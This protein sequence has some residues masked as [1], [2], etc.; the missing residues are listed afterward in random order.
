MRKCR[1]TTLSSIF[2]ITIA[3]KRRLLRSYWLCYQHMSACRPSIHVLIYGFLA[4]AGSLFAEDKPAAPATPHWAFVAPVNADH[5]VSIDAYLTAEHKKQGLVPQEPAEDLI[6]LRR[7]Y[8]DLIGLPP[9]LSDQADFS[10]AVKSDRKAAMVSVVDRLLASPQYGERWG[11]HFMDIW[12]YSDWHGLGAQ[13]R[14]SQKHIWHWRDWIVESMNADKGYDRMIQEMLAGDELE[15]EN[16]DVLRATGFLARNYFLFNRTSWLDDMVEHT[17]KAF[18]GITMNC[19][20][21]HAHKYDPFTHEEYYAFRAIFEPYHVRLDELPGQT[22]LEK[23]GLPRAYDLHLD[24]PTYLHVKGDEKN[25]DT[26]KAILPAVP[27]VL[28]S[29]P[30]D[31]HPLKLPA[32]A[33]NPALQPWVLANHLATAQEQ[34]KIARAAVDKARQKLEVQDKKSKPAQSA[35]VNPAPSAQSFNDDFA[36]ANPRLW[37]ILDDGWAYR[38]GVLRQSRTA[39][40]RIAALS[41]AE[42]PSDF[43]ATVKFRITGGTTYKS[44][45]FA[46]DTSDDYEVLVY[47]S[48][49]R[50]APKLQ[51]AYGKASSFTYPAEGTQQRPVKVGENYELTVRVQGS[52]I[53]VSVNGEHALAFDLPSRKAGLFQLV[54]YDA[55]AEF[56]NFKLDPLSADVQLAKTSAPAASK[57]AAAV[58]VSPKDAGAALK[59][60]ELELAAAELRPAM[61]QAVYNADT[62]K[63]KSGADPKLAAAAS[64]AEVKFKLAEAIANI[65]RLELDALPS[66]GKKRADAEKKLKVAKD[67]LAT[68]RKRAESPDGNYS[69]INASLKAFEGPD[70]SVDHT[71]LPFPT[72][73]TG[74]RLA[75]ARW[76]ADRQNPLTAR[77]LVNHV[78]MRH[79]GQPLVSNVMDFGNQSKAPPLQPLLDSLAIDFMENGWNLKRLHRLMVLSDTY[80]MTSSN[81]SAATVNRERDAENKYYWRM[82]PVRM[83]SQT[84]RDSLLHLAN[85]LE[86]KLGGPTIDPSAEGSTFRRSLYFNQTR[87]EVSRFLEMFDNVN[88]LD[89]Y[90]RTESIVPQQALALMNAKTSLMSAESIANRLDTPSNE[91]FIRAAFRLLLGM[92]P[93]SGEMKTCQEALKE[94][95]NDKKSRSALIH[96]LMNHQDFITIR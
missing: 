28:S 10:K 25:Q 15:P 39:G 34:I 35:T 90:R 76:I 21:C 55:T 1:I 83:D 36:A 77:V 53:N 85:K 80:A 68:A 43:Q 54:T 17:G 50:N 58:S 11:R 84:V 93:T 63:A 66:D 8:L 78:W 86:L 87:D 59:A 91:D 61:L 70:E 33:Q 24:K 96:T 42:H 92:T 56:I 7:V 26:S 45:G 23:D 4:M 20:K 75:L 16:P 32:P 2:R 14:Y 27:V 62:A 29:K 72:T 3:A 67:A 89:C 52:L 12:R 19:V 94:L 49:S 38:D 46:F 69:S 81:A 60:V 40:K 48:A 22:D 88:V 71:K 44:V 47:M 5:L 13:L 57:A 82:N 9:T 64:S 30:L 73:S 74:R 65:A 31:I 6:W 37:E 18:L 41:V 95:G 79:F 51:I